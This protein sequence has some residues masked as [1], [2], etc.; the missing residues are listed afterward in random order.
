MT[1]ETLRLLQEFMTKV[2]EAGD[3]EEGDVLMRG[4]SCGELTSC[5][6]FHHGGGGCDK[7]QHCVTFKKLL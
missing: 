4:G 3:G 7:L 5:N 6:T 1:P 2:Q